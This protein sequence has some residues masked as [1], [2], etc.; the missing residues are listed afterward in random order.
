MPSTPASGLEFPIISRNSSLL[1]C[2]MRAFHLTNPKSLGRYPPNLKFLFTVSSSPDGIVIAAD[3]VVAT[4]DGIAADGIVITADAVIVAADTV[5]VAADTRHR[6]WWYCR[7]CWCCCHCCWWYRHLC[8]WCHHVCW[9]CCGCCWCCFCWYCYRR[10]RLV[11][12]EVI[13]DRYQVCTTHTGLLPHECRAWLMSSYLANWL[14][15]VTT[16]SAP[17]SECRNTCVLNYLKQC[18]G[19]HNLGTVA[20]AMSWLSSSWQVS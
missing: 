7:R 12:N 5:I 16:S 20:Q 13:L 8:W 19:Q 17:T 9:R 1:G 4:A 15:L 11:I 14:L 18:L 3:A 2:T 10:V 6:C